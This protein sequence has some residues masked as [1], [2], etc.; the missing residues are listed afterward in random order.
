M[1]ETF[2]VTFVCVPIMMYGIL[3]I[4]DPERAFRLRN[5][6]QIRTIELSDWGVFSQLL[7]GTMFI[8]IATIFAQVAIG[9]T[10]VVLVIA[11]AVLPFVRWYG[12]KPDWLFGAG[13]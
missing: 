12:R 10:A 11:I 2:W 3:C 4:V 8:L 9:P 1:R 6:F 5:L 13:R 7:M